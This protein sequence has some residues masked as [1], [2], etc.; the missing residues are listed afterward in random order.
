MQGVMAADASPLGGD[1]IEHGN[2]NLGKTGRQIG[3]GLSDSNRR[4]ADKRQNRL[5]QGTVSIHQIMRLP[6]LTAEPARGSC[7]C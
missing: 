5:K 7:L 2:V 4:P 1:P 3:N 6:R